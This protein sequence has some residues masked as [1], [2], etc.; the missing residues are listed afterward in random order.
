MR[1][2]TSVKV[3]YSV[4][5][6]TVDCKYLLFLQDFFF[7]LKPKQYKNANIADCLKKHLE[8]HKTKEILKGHFSFTKPLINWDSATKQQN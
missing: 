3:N 4:K 2:R 1:M 7:I 6:L 5:F 8:T